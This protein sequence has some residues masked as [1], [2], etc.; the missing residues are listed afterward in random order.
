MAME[1]SAGAL[2]DVGGPVV[3]PPAFGI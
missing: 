3:Y 2:D 1:L